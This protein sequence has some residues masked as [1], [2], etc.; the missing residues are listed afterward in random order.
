MAEGKLPL[1]DPCCAAP[2]D[3]CVMLHPRTA[4]VTLAYMCHA[5][6]LPYLGQERATASRAGV[7]SMRAAAQRA[8]LECDLA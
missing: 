4:C 3:T 7:G 8:G 5:G 6:H 2:S 1:A